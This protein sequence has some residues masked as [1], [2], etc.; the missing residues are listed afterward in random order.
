[1]S[2]EKQVALVV[3]V[4]LLGQDQAYAEGLRLLLE[5]TLLDDD[6]EGSV[7]VAVVKL[8]K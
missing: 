5:R 3:T 8:P 6:R 4:V 1:M 2:D 7:G